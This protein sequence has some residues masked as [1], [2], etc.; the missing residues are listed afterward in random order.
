M[1]TC[2]KVPAR[3][4]GRATLT[5][6]QLDKNAHFSTTAHAQTSHIRK[7][8]S[9]AKERQRAEREQL[10]RLLKESPGKRDARN[11]LKHFDSAKKNDTPAAAKVKQAVS[12]AVHNEWGLAKSGVNL[13][14][15]YE[16]TVF[17]REPLPEKAYEEGDKD[18]PLHLAL[19]KLRQPQALDDKTLGGIAL[20]LSQL[21][22]LGLSTAVV[23]DCDEDI[24]QQTADSD[25]VY[26]TV[27]E[28]AR[29]LVAALEDY[30]EP[31]ALLVE[32]AL[33]FSDLPNN[34]PSTA[35][36]RGDVQVQNDYLLFLPIDDGMIPVI[37]SFAYNS[38]LKKVKV[39]ADDVLLALI[40][41]FAGIS[42]QVND[43]GNI[44]LDKKKEAMERPILDR[45]IILDP[46]GGIP[47]LSRAD[48]AHV[49]VN[50]EAE[51]RNIKKE[52][53]QLSMA[54]QTRG[55]TGG[56]MSL[57]SSN[58]FSKFVEDELASIPDSSQQQLSHTSPTLHL[59]N[60]DVVERALKLLPPSSSAL[61]ITPAEAATQPLSEESQSKHAQNPLIHNLITDKPMI[62][63]SLPTSRAT[64]FFD[65]AAPN[66]ATFLKKGIPLT[67]IPDPRVTGPWQPPSALNPSIEL[68][69][70]PRI[71]FP[72]LV[73]L[74]NDSFRRKL[75]AKD[76]IE[77]IR[78]RVA[79]I[80]IAGDYEGGAIC[81]WERPSTLKGSTHP[82][83]TSVDSPYWVPYLDKFAVLTSSQGS[84][85]VSDIVWAA[86]T[87]TCFPGGV[88]WRSR[89]SNPVNKWY[90]ERSTG[91][92]NLPGGQWTMFWTTEGVTE[93][94]LE[95]SEREGLRRWDAYVDVCSGIEPSWA[96]G[97]KSS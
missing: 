95:R 23:L 5:L 37:P 43:T 62:S 65:T 97:K 85:G 96:D 42:G 77:R 61:I 30:N 56:S 81:T 33:S 87:R 9:S 51:Y 45:I 14:N 90:Q 40:R 73:D 2:C 16:P 67:M 91:M 89:T 24:T 13:G 53:Q 6:P 74:I 22:Q 12:E 78:G 21:A 94:W 25:V 35:R 93:E 32:H 72:K 3:G 31:G 49:F 44:A 47:S 10:T 1:F 18:E 39:Q 69:D 57:G 15:L 36:V 59:S 27:M 80:I 55:S 82:D 41:D 79:G 38:E 26:K 58:P 17:T 86:L 68:A 76:Y 75:D 34:V 54:G 4:L 48:G 8:S 50:L 70:D 83:V 20:T 60:L 7:S 64:R 52:L 84:G 11:F 92:W 29:R 71:N 28:Q 46:L 63:S 19:V 66:P 88:V